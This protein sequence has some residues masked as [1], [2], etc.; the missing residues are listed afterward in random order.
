MIQSFVALGYEAGKN[1]HGA[2]YDWRKAPDGH[3]TGLYPQL[4][5]LLE[6]TVARNGKPAHVITHSLGGPTAL[7]FLNRQSDAWLAQHVA[8]FAP[9]AGVFGGALD[10]V[11]A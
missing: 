8:S 11:K 5:V 3:A 9:I 6:E 4:R 1:M 2:P 10:Q 7:G